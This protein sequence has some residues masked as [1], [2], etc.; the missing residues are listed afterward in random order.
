MALTDTVPPGADLKPVSFGKYLLFEKLGEGGIAQVHRAALNGPQGE[1]FL[2]VK[3]ILPQLCG[4]RDLVKAFLEEAK[5]A[6]MLAHENI[7]R[8]CDFGRMEKSFFLAAEYLA[9]KD[10]RC[11]LARSAEKGPALGLEHALYIASQICSGLDYAHKLKDA[12]GSPTPMYHR[13]ICPQNVILTFDGG[14]KIV[15][16]G[17]VRATYKSAVAKH[18]MFKAKVAYMSPEQALGDRVDHRSDIFSA[19]ILLYEMATAKKVYGG[20]TMQ[21]L[22]KVRKAEFEPPETAR[23]GLPPKLYEILAKSLAKEKD[24]RYQTCEA[25]LEAIEDCLSGFSPKP[26]AG[27]VSEYMKKLF[28]GE[29]EAYG[30]ASSCTVKKLLES[31]STPAGGAEGQDATHSIPYLATSQ[32]ES[33]QETPAGNSPGAA[34]WGHLLPALELH[35]AEKTEAGPFP[36]T[37]APASYDPPQPEPSEVADDA[38][39]G[40][41]PATELQN[42]LQFVQDILKKAQATVDEESFSR[43][44]TRMYYAGVPAF[45]LAAFILSWTYWPRENTEGLPQPEML[46]ASSIS[47]PVN[48]PVPGN[49]VSSNG[50][51]KKDGGSDRLAEAAALQDKGAALSEKNPKEA[52]S[53]L[54]KALELNPRSVRAN[55]HLGLT[56]TNL[57]NLPKAVE[58]YR[59]TI[60]LDPSFADAYFNLG[61]IYARQKNYPNA[62]QMY[63]DAVRLAPS[64]LDEALFNLSV[65]QEKQ[66]KKKQ[67][68]ENLERAVQINPRNEMAQKL[69]VKLKRNS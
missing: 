40:A 9:G 2:V 62:E 45:I 4:E 36:V 54:L 41:D 46:A 11:I 65:V 7:V 56:Y 32:G 8:V 55:F 20:E 69:L 47:S 60:Q 59:K 14:V 58:Y 50:S 39:N 33:R 17:I 30:P 38:G 18:E 19:G 10:L 49:L 5:L 53:L 28:E 23:S 21:A 27:G 22:A 31:S 16:F 63:I 12:Q 44:K 25:M 51:P 48:E 37:A 67:C 6:S 24:Q 26:M 52:Q 66:G 42:D 3:R 34:T 13:D 29:I 64:Y 1:K 43:R 15:D 57:N 68:L 61:Y 35:N